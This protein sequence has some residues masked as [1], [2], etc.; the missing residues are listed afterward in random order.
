MLFLYT[1]ATVLIAA[2]LSPSI[3]AEISEGNVI[4]SWQQA[5]EAL[6]DYS[7]LGSP[8]QRSLTTLRILYNT[9]PQQFSV[10]QEILANNNILKQTARLTDTA[11]E[12]R[13]E[14]WRENRVPTSIFASAPQGHAAIPELDPLF[15]EPEE[16][17]ALDAPFGPNDMSWLT[18][19]P[20][21]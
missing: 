10:R 3:L 8:V 9:V 5:M 1:S 17:L 13:Q 20:F 2:R 15:L 21:D 11:A 6:G 18:A 12:S 19:A 7:P 4:T 14:D 16:F